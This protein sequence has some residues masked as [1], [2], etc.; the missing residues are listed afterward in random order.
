MGKVEAVMELG[1]VEAEAV[2][3]VEWVAA[4]GKVLAEEMLARHHTGLH[5]KC[6]PPLRACH[7]H[8]SATL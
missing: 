2:R 6:I 4:V 1:E 3:W 8:Q 5:G 7:C